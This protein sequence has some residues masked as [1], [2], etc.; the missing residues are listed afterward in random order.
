MAYHLDPNKKITYYNL[1]FRLVMVLIAL[2]LLSLTGRMVYLMVLDHHFLQGQG[3][4]RAL[5]T[6]EIPAYRG[7]LLDRNG[8]ALAV[9]SPVDAIWVDPP[10][11]TPTPQQLTTLAK[12]LQLKPQTIQ[13]KVK[14]NIDREFIYLLRGVQPDV[15][16]QIKALNIPGLFLREEYRR[17]YPEGE[18]T[19]H[20]LGFTNVDDNGQE[21]LELAYN[22]VL[23]GQ[24]GLRKV[25]KDRY[26]RVVE[27][28]N[29]IREPKPGQDITL[30]IDR[31]IQYIAY[32]ALKDQ[33]AKFAA[34]S[35]SVVVIDIK[36]GEVLAMANVPSFNP[37][38][39][40]DDKDGRYRNRAVTDTFEPGSTLKTFTAYLGLADGKYS[41]DTIIDT[42]PGWFKL[43]KNIVR[44]EHYKGAITVAQ[45]L[46][47]SSNVGISKIVLSLPPNQLWTTLNELGFGQSTY[48]GFPGESAGLLPARSYWDPFILSTLSFGYGM[49]TTTLQLAH[50]YATIANYG[51]QVPVSLLKLDQAPV[52]KQVLEPKVTKQLITIMETVLEGG[53][54]AVRAQ[55]PGYLVAGKTGTS[56]MVGPKG[57]MWN[58]HN[59]Q[60]AGLAPA[61]NPRYVVVVHIS[62]PRK[63]GYEGGQ[64][65]APVFA[66]VMAGVLQI[67]N[68]PADNLNN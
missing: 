40:P 33:V 52:G 14:K 32:K 9:S 16:A 62:D 59:A 27:D 55:V 38:F 41:P 31:R 30:S 8:Q 2:V 51:V 25:V 35:G 18:V 1:R 26:G 17:Y 64:V 46:Q 23:A 54:T 44:D 37:N 10:E 12:L 28:V 56:R 42:A 49:T 6:I 61:T 50:A 3:D 58:H 68:V 5:R 21:G 29:L 43:G 15:G 53:G 63:I 48:S 20:I 34:D 66:K 39:R 45:V 22:S 7:M 36:T 57:Y 67:M 47:Y 19:A 13:T 65:A 60:F 11:F 24:S 4:A